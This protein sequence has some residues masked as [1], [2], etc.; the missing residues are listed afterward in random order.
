MACVLARCRALSHPSRAT[1]DHSPPPPSAPPQSHFSRA[2]AEYTTAL[3]LDCD[4]DE[5]CAV[6]YANRAAAAMAMGK[7]ERAMRDCSEALRRRPQM[8]K[9]R[10][11]RARAA[12]AAGQ[13][14]VAVCEL[15]EVERTTDAATCESLGVTSDLGEARRLL[16]QQQRPSSSS[17]GAGASSSA[18]GTKR[19]GTKWDIPLGGSGESANGRS[20][21]HS[22]SRSRSRFA[23]P[24]ASA[25][26]SPKTSAPSSQK[27]SSQSSAHSSSRPTDAP[28]VSRKHAKTSFSYAKVSLF[29]VPLHLT[30]IL[31]T[32]LTRSP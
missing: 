20:H 9:A 31:L 5:Y 23:S 18:S 16:A 27:Y 6:I 1:S 29:Y 15:E 3:C 11:R 8:T 32:V 2:Y 10:L 13:H 4:H 28:G 12:M 24:S 21:S 22:R 25:S 17:S 30:R 14:T 19:S 7:F 26:A